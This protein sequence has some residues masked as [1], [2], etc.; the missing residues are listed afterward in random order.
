MV[1]A[2]GGAMRD[3]RIDR[4]TATSALRSR[5]ARQRVGGRHADSRASTVETVLAIALLT[6]ERRKCA[7]HSAA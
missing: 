7:S 6:K 3:A 1:K 5:H 4:A 2:I